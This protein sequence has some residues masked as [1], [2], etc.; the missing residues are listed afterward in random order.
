MSEQIDVTHKVFDMPGSLRRGSKTLPEGDLKNQA[1]KQ[2][3]KIL[4]G[5]CNQ[6][7]TSVKRWSILSNLRRVKGQKT[8]FFNWTS[9][10]VGLSL[11]KF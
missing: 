2:H 7:R 9:F 3:N 4:P 10:C 1:E 11:E 6:R 5:E 8:I